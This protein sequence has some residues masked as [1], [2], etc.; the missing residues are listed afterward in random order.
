[1]H[2]VL[3]RIRKNRPSLKAVDGFN[4][5]RWVP[6]QFGT[7][8]AAQNVL[9]RNILARLT[10]SHGRRS[11]DRDRPAPPER[12]EAP[13]SRGLLSRVALPLR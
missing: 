3:E 10:R 7:P 6:G 13:R 1:M 12:G 9:I 8:D 5:R 4:C 2:R 11:A